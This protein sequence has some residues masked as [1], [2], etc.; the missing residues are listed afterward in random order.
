MSKNGLYSN[1]FNAQVKQENNKNNGEDSLE[2]DEDIIDEST[3]D[4]KNMNIEFTTPSTS[5]PKNKQTN[6]KENVTDV[7]ANKNIEYVINIKILV[8]I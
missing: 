7:E 6:L 4:N 3:S 1:L 8:V 5:Q 2:S